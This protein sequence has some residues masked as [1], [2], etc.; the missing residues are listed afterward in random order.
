M[1]LPNV[2][3]VDDEQGVLNSI[4]RLFRKENLK[5]LTAS[6][7]E[8]GLAVLEQHRVNVVISDQRMPGMSGTD[9]LKKVRLLYPDTVR[10]ILSGYA[11]MHCVVA[12]V[13]D[14]N[15]YRFI[16]KP[17][18]ETELKE[19]V[20]E[21]LLLAHDL[22]EQRRARASLESRASELEERSARY[23]EL[24]ELQESLLKSSRD[25]LD[26]L[27]VAVAALDDQGRM[28]YTNRRFANDY[29]HLPGTV[30]GQVAGE[31]WVSAVDDNFVG[32]RDL[33]IDD[34]SHSAH[35]DRISIGGNLHA[36]ITMS[37]Q[38]A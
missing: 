14:G 30:L 8:D 21:C 22:A 7:A 31:P 24:I 36:L 3:F 6:C 27:P 2:L 13:N 25:V 17:W 23:S 28:I 26:Q 18:D 5:V 9:F 20:N 34:T 12:A 16:G 11:E 35:I 19:A 29:G 4:K 33:R 37:P 38:Y 15:V 10:C 1:T 32:N